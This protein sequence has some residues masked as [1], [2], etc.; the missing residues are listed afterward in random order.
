MYKTLMLAL[1]LLV[2]AAWLQAQDT[3]GKSAGA[4]STTIEGCLKVA[5]GH[6]Y[7]VESNGDAHRL[8]GYAN[9]LKNHVGHDVKIT[10]MHGEKTVCTTEQGLGSTAHLV[11]VFKVQSIQH[12][13]DTC[14]AM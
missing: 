9:K 3:M 1:A 5:G 13:A 7:L 10:G 11:D 12:V 6:Y 2:S 8:S 14:K 4:S